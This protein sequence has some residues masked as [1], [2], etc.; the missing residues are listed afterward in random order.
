MKDRK[1]IVLWLIMLAGFLDGVSRQL[2]APGADFGPADMVF[3]LV[4]TLLVFIWYRFDTEERSY[5]RTPFLN[6]A[7]V[8]L[9]LLAL[10]YYFFR[11][12]GFSRGS[13]AT[14][15]FIVCMV[16]YIVLQSAGEYAAYFAWRS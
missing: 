15:V 16:A 13:V 5:R 3:T 11:S 7:V 6:V 10:P 9:A 8:A 4:T 14:G 2:T 1:R 12:R